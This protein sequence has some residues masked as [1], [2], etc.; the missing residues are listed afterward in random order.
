[1]LRK[2]KEQNLSNAE[3]RNPFVCGQRVVLRPGSRAAAKF[4]SPFSGSCSSLDERLACLRRRSYAGKPS[5]P[6]CSF[7]RRDVDIQ[8]RIVK[9]IIGAALKSIKMKSLCY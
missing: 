7:K 6:V 3:L 5:N 1:M 8:V 2:A 4:E 9:K